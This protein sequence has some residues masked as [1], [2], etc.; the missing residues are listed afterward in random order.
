MVEEH[1]EKTKGHSMDRIPQKQSHGE[2]ALWMG[3]KEE[4]T[5]QE[6]ST[7]LVASLVAQMVKNLPAMQKA[8]VHSLGRDDPLEKGMATHSSVLACRIPWTEEPGGLQS[9]GSQRIRH[10]WATNTFTLSLALL[11]ALFSPPN[12][13]PPRQHRPWLAWP[14]G[15]TSRL[16]APPTLTLKPH[17]TCHN[18]PVL[19][20]GRP[21]RAV[22]VTHYF[23][24]KINYCRS[25]HAHGQPQWALWSGTRPFLACFLIIKSC[26]T[27]CDPMDC[28]PP[29]SSVHGILQARTLEG[30]AM[31]SISPTQGSNMHLLCL[32]HWQAGSLPVVP[33][34]KPPKWE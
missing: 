15:I 23:L 8:Q 24:W 1:E 27:L 17:H 26:L 14:A 9:M 7:G 10:D 25:K 4:E 20:R 13:Q 30:V 33:P 3:R 21:S 18:P 2:R 11:P 12:G 29:G 32:L 19:G 28:S 22:L 34:G 16:P 6:H 5:H 31:P